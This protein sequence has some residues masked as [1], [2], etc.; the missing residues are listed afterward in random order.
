MWFKNHKL[1][2]Y[3]RTPRVSTV[4]VCQNAFVVELRDAA[5][6]VLQSDRKDEKEKRLLNKRLEK[7]V[8][9]IGAINGDHGAISTG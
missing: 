3:V 4:G 8:K 5:L 1:W 7:A 9:N 2:F 6:L